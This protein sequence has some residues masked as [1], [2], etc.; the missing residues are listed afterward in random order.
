MDDD[1]DESGSDAMYKRCRRHVKGH[2]ACWLLK[3]RLTCW[4]RTPVYGLDRCILKQGIHMVSVKNACKLGCEFVIEIARAS[5]SRPPVV[6][7]AC[8]GV[9]EEAKLLQ[10]GG[11]SCS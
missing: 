5:I 1:F 6:A 8:I 11:V 7:G 2:E 4:P 9:S 3:V 10:L